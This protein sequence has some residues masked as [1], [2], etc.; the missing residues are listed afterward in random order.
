MVPRAVHR[1]E[2]YPRLLKTF[3]A[4]TYKVAEFPSHRPE[5]HLV[6]EYAFQSLTRIRPVNDTPESIEAVDVSDSGSG[7]NS[8][9]HDVQP[10]HAK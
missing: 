6:G 2:D 7:V 10:E 4:L 9:W 3:S 5:P 1:Y 8:R